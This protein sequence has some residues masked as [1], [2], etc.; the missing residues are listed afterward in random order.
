MKKFLIDY[1][2][3][4][5]IFAT[6]ISSFEEKKGLFPEKRDFKKRFQKEISKRDFKE[7]FQK[8]ISKRDFIKRF[9]MEIANRNC[10]RRYA[11]IAIDKDITTISICYFKVTLKK[12][13][14]WL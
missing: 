6:T 11:N 4:E 3:L 5:D 2:I 10:K 9:Q 7:R 13:V 12:I 1:D 14:R 8:E